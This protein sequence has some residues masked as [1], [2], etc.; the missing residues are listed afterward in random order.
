[1]YI[2]ETIPT[3]PINIKTINKHLPN[4]DKSGVIPNDAPVVPNAEQTSKI[5]ESKL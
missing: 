2:N 5:I 1:M 3:L 4:I